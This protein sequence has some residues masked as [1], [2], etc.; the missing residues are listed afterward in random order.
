M[1]RNGGS[2]RAKVIIVLKSGSNRANVVVFRQKKKFG[3]SGCFR[4]KVVVIGKS[5]CIRA[6]VVVFGQSG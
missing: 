1:F 4:T 2:V 3:Q 5:C 6:E